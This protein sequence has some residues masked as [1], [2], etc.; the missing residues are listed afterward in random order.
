[1]AERAVISTDFPK[2]T[3]TKVFLKLRYCSLADC[4]W[5]MC[6]RIQIHSRTAAAWRSS[7]CTG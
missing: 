7:G 1:V 4:P 3:N 2:W 5:S 6:C